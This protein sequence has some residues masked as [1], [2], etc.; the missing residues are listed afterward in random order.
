MKTLALALAAVGLV[1]IAGCGGNTASCADACN[2]VIS[3]ANRLNVSTPYSNVQECTAECA[4]NTCP[5]R[6][7]IID[8]MNGLTCNTSIDDN[9]FTCA[10]ISGC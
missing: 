1:A 6:Q 10:S 3:C 9:A 8:C 2:H 7:N 5:H 4:A